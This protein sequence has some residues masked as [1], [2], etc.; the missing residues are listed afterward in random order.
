MSVSANLPQIVFRDRY[1][2][3]AATF[4]L[5]SEEDMVLE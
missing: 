2:P 3:R 5:W 4:N 1:R